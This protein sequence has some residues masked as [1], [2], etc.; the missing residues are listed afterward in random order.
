MSG[1]KIVILFVSIIAGVALLGAGAFLAF[2]FLSNGNELNGFEYADQEYTYSEALSIL[3]SGDTEAGIAALRTAKE[4]EAAAKRKETYLSVLGEETYNALYQAKVGDKI[5]FGA[6]EQDDNLSNGSEAITWRVLDADGEGRIL[7]IS[8]YAIE[9]V[10]YHK[11]AVDITWEESDMRKW[12]NDGFISEVF[13]KEESWLIPRILVK[14]DDNPVYGTEGGNDTVDRVFLLSIEEAET[15]F[16][17]DLDRKTSATETAK[18]HYAYCDPFDNTAWW[19]RSPSFKSNKA[20]LVSDTGEILRGA[21]HKVTERY[22]A[23]RPAM[24]IDLA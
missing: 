3:E 23:T 10:R 17:D 5:T 24:W 11:K 9:C 12:L 20:A 21:Y 4:P 2:H 7:V 8:E 19:L 18:L 14:N 13:S 16:K 6:I 15:Y 22:F 1:K